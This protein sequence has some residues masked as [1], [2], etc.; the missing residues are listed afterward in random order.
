MTD[1]PDYKPAG[2]MSVATIAAAKAARPMKG[3]V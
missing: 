3:G 1:P 2:E